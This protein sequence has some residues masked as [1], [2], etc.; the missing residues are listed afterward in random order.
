MNNA[1]MEVKSTGRDMTFLGVVTII[2]GVAAIVAPYIT[3]LSV[4]L[5]VGLLVIVGGFL[6]MLWA[7]GE[8]SFGKG[9]VAFAIG[10]LTLLCGLAL[11][12]Q[13]LFAFGFLTVLIAV[14]LFADGIAEVIGAFR[15]GHETG[16]AW[17]LFGGMVSILLAVMIWRQYPLSGA[18]AIGVL[19][20]VKL[21]LI[22]TTMIAGGSAMR[23]FARTRMA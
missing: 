18:W 15:W 6:R 21:L 10:G 7:F 20:G 11:V 14:Y 22:G 4:V 5:S 2:L 12:T 16:R 13:P 1:E 8:S 9:V 23:S 3:G 17:L 19:L